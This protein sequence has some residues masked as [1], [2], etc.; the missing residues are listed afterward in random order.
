[1]KM[2][3]AT[4]RTSQFQNIKQLLLQTS[5]TSLTVY[6]VSSYKKN[7]SIPY[8]STDNETAMVNKMRIE[9]AVDDNHVDSLLNVIRSTGA[10][11]CEHNDDTIAVYDLVQCI[12]IRTGESG[13]TA[14]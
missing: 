11:N 5:T 8:I 7:T 2:I 14:L 13:T 3:V 6:P 4:I 1:M 9:I 10:D 12:R